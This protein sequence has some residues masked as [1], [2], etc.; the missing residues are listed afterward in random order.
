MGLLNR[1][2]NPEQLI[3]KGDIYR[4]QQ[5]YV[6]AIECFNEAIKI[7]PE[8]LLPEIPLTI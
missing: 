4:E 2:K 3:E 7:E 5:E 6:K 1:S 8:N